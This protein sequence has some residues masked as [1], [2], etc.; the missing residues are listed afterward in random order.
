MQQIP[1]S[2]EFG[3][4]CS[5]KIFIRY[6]GTSEDLENHE[7][8]A[9]AY[10]FSISGYAA[11]TKKT[12]ESLLG[13]EVKIRIVAHENGSFLDVFNISWDTVYKVG[14]VLAIASWLGIDGKLIYRGSKKILLAIQKKITELIIESGGST[15]TIIREIYNSEN[16]S[17]EEK[18]SLVNLIKDNEVRKGLD[19][20]T[21]PLDKN[22][23][24][25]IEVSNEEE[26]SFSVTSSQRY[27]FK[28][29][30]PDIIEEEPYQDT[31]SIIYLSPELS[32]WKFQGKRIFWADVYDEEFI[33]KTKDK[34]F[35]ELKGRQYFV[36]GIKT[37]TRNDDKI[38]GTPSYT[39]EKATEV[40]E[41]LS[42]LN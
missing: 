1:L 35:S 38:K 19:G 23:Y 7:I 27:A 39:I 10:A 6:S 14:G 12:I 40:P 15:D 32:K 13:K 42:I 30:P 9:S 34:K 25:K 37:T 21:S 20:F 26:D 41:Q 29:I 22:G 16:L 8:D 33:N 4:Q 17:L 18:D 11:F 5:E 36:S 2:D 24:E 3:G 31:V 28:Y